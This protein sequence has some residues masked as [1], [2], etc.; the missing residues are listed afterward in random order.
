M[1]LQARFVWKCNKLLR[2]FLQAV[3]LFS[4]YYTALSRVSDYKHHWSDVLTGS[5]Q[6]II[7]AIIVVLFVSDLFPNCKNNYYISNASSD[8]SNLNRSNKKNTEFIENERSSV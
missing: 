2:P 7:V 6:G 1:Y 4:A 5:I 3:V 8:S